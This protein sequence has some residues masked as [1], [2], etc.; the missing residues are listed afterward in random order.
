MPTQLTVM[1]IIDN[2]FYL[3]FLLLPPILRRYQK[4]GL[5]HSPISPFLFFTFIG[6]I[7]LILAS[8][9]YYDRLL[10]KIQSTP[11]PPEELLEQWT[12]DSE[13]I[14]VYGFGWVASA[15]YFLV[16]RIII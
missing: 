12:S 14:V 7:C 15:I 9:Y 3:T 2:P 1:Y 5:N 16:W 8:D 4:S 10:E 11:N 6:W 13:M